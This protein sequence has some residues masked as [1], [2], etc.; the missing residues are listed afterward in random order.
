MDICNLEFRLKS[1]NFIDRWSRVRRFLTNGT[2]YYIHV[3]MN[4]WVHL[5]TI[6]NQRSRV[7]QDLYGLSPWVLC[8]KCSAISEIP[9]LL[10]PFDLQWVWSL[11]DQ[12]ERLNSVS[13]LLFIKAV[14]CWVLTTLSVFVS[15]VHDH[16]T[17]TSWSW[18]RSDFD[19]SVS[20][21]ADMLNILIDTLA[22]LPGLL[23]AA[24]LGHTPSL[25]DALSVGSVTAE[26]MCFCFLTRPEIVIVSV[27]WIS[28]GDLF[29]DLTVPA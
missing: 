20:T 9:Q 16:N 25:L 19:Y 7:A 22:F 1:L 2:R 15:G 6:F 11:I 4:Y 5:V 17:F 21:F 24:T 27:G 3:W 10:C 8:R 23:R 13:S 12:S 14:C 26:S 29:V 28:F 18:Q